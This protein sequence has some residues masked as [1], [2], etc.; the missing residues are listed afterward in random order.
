MSG[1]DATDFVAIAILL[2]FQ[3]NFVLALA[4]FSAAAYVPSDSFKLLFLLLLH[5]C[6]YWCRYF[7]V[8]VTVS[9]NFKC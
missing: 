4:T 3:S 9:T 1:P 7:G 2:L 5:I 6:C 8:I